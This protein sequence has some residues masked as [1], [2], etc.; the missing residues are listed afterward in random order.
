M[1]LIDGDILAYKVSSACEE[2]VHWGDDLWTLHADAKEGKSQVDLWLKDIQVDLE[3]G[4]GLKVFL[5]SKDNYRLDVYSEYKANRVGKRKPMILAELKRH[6]EAV[7]DAVSVPTLEADDV[8]GMAASA[9]PEHSIIVSIDKDFKSVPCRLYNPDKPELGVLTISEQEA[10]YWFMYQTLVGD[11]TDNYSGCKG[12]GPK[13]AA[14]ILKDKETLFDMWQAVV[15]AYDSAGLSSKH[16]LVQA[17][18]ARILRNGE[19]SDG[20]VQLWSPP[21]EPK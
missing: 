2:A 1:L 20:K 14:D 17:R 21:K 13:K 18:V 11:S 5:S 9:A 6:M 12:V 7:W 4:E 15:R 8:I 10:D 3:Y 16:A 19:Y